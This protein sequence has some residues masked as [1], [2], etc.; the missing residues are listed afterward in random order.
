MKVSPF[1][2]THHIPVDKAAEVIFSAKGNAIAVAFEI[3]KVNDIFRLS[4]AG[5]QIIYSAAELVGPDDGRTFIGYAI[6]PAY[7]IYTLQIAAGA[8]LHHVLREQAGQHRIP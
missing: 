6:V 5:G 3:G 1:R 2:G 7:K 4:H 8:K